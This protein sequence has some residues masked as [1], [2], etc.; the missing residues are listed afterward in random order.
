MDDD[1]DESYSTDYSATS[2]LKE[3]LLNLRKY[4]EWEAEEVLIYLVNY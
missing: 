4:L 3:H 1:D 2:G